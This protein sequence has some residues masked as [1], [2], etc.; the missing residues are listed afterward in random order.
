MASA[1]SSATRMNLPKN[2]RPHVG[3]DVRLRDRDLAALDRMIASRPLK[4]PPLKLG[5]LRVSAAELEA[6]ADARRAAAATL[7]RPALPSV[8]VPEA[9]QRAEVGIAYRAPEEA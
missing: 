2:Q 7:A 6:R 9:P 8:A 5:E 4:P 3:S 1:G